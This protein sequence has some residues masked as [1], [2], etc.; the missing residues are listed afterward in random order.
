ME[1]GIS[2]TFA[3]GVA[4]HLPNTVWK[5]TASM[6]LPSQIDKDS[7]R[8]KSPPEM[9]GITSDSARRG[10][11]GAQ[12]LSVQADSN[13]LSQHNVVNYTIGSSNIL[14][15]PPLETKFSKPSDSGEDLLGSSARCNPKLL[16]V[17][18]PSTELTFN[19]R[20]SSI[21]GEPEQ[22]YPLRKQPTNTSTESPWQRLHQRRTYLEAKANPLPESH[23]LRNKWQK[24]LNFLPRG[25]ESQ[26]PRLSL[27]KSSTV[28]HEGQC[29][30]KQVQPVVGKS[31]TKDGTLL[32]ML[33]PCRS[34]VDVSLSAKPPLNKYKPPSLRQISLYLNGSQILQKQEIG[35]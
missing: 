5:G 25:G 19:P 15:G 4:S 1:E 14:D 29:V 17:I 3:P 10:A 18:T 21:P 12:R 20:T 11:T 31:S 34:K 27:V 2:P 35:R 24:R 8:S 33:E 16:T 32:I 13:T 9:L 26:S 7:S 6:N 22:N 30:L 23:T 28:G